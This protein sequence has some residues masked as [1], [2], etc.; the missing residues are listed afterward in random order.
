[1]NSRIVRQ[2]GMESSSQG[3]A[4]PDQNGIVALPGENLN[5]GSDL[6]DFRSPDE[7]HFQ[8]STTALDGG[9]CG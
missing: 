2:L 9:Y 3:L 8:G 7:D 5:S 6:G 4:L 1:M